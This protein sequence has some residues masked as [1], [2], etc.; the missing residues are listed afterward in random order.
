[1]TCIECDKPAVWVRATQFAGKHPYCLEHAEQQA[2]FNQ[3][4]SYTYWYEIDEE[5]EK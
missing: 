2:D 5:Q 3:N 4:D 1:M